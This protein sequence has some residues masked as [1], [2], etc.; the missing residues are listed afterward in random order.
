[1]HTPH[2]IHSPSPS[3]AGALAR[4]RVQTLPSAQFANRAEWLRQRKAALRAG[5]GY[6]AGGEKLAVIATALGVDDG[7]A[8]RMMNVADRTD[9]VTERHL[10]RLDG[11]EFASVAE[12][13]RAVKLG[14]AGAPVAR[15]A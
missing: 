1:M 10:S 3:P 14:V 4:T 9:F 13:V 2:A 7:T 12:A 8:S 6:C 5:F 15:A 11:T